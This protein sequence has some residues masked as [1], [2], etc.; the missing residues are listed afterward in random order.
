MFHSEVTDVQKEQLC[1]WS[2]VFMSDGQL[3]LGTGDRVRLV[4]RN[5][6]QV[7]AALKDYHN[8]L[9]HL[10]VSKSLRLLSDRSVVRPQGLSRSSPVSL[11]SF[12]SSSVHRLNT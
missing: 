3:H 6:Q 2:Y 12:P 4:L 1:I 7:E 11:T 9:N 5:R 8:D 10:N